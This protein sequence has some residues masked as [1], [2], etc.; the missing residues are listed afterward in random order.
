M[1]CF[2]GNNW[3]KS[4]IL[5]FLEADLNK[6]TEPDNFQCKEKLRAKSGRRFSLGRGGGALS[7][8]ASRA[9]IFLLPRPH[10]CR[11]RGSGG[12][13]VVGGGDGAFS[14]D[15]PPRAGGRGRAPKVSGDRVSIS[16][17]AGGHPMAVGVRVEALRVPGTQRISALTV[18][19]AAPWHWGPRPGLMAQ[20]R[21][22]RWFSRRFYFLRCL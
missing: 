7:A 19:L 10:F 21:G 1:S 22:G 11:R 18:A 16:K 8:P 17:W 15:P 14:W 2:L 20:G 13:H 6:Q 12:T 4:S 3:K 5:T 9:P